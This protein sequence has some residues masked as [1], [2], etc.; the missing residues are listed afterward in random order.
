MR[1]PT[2]HLLLDDK[3]MNPRYE[4]LSLDIFAEINHI[5]W[6]EICL[7]DGDA[8]AR[9]F[10]ISESG[11]FDLGTKIKISLYYLNEAGTK[12]QVFQGIVT[13]HTVELGARGQQLRIE[14]QHAAYQ[15][16]RQRNSTVFAAK[17]DGQV[18][19]E[20]LDA[21]PGVVNAS[22]ASM[23]GFKHEGL[24][25]YFATD[26]DFML[27]RCQA[28]GW[29]V[30][31]TPL[32]GLAIEDGPKVAAS[33]PNNEVM[34]FNINEIYDIEISLDAADQYE[35]ATAQ[36]WDFKTQ[37]PTTAVVEPGTKASPGDMNPAA[38]KGVS[39]GIT[40]KLFNGTIMEP[41]ELKAWTK[42]TMVRARMAFMRGRFEVQGDAK[43]KPGE[44]CKIIDVGK[45]F[46]G[47]AYITGVRHR[48]NTAGWFTDV[49]I[50]MPDKPHFRAQA[51]ADAPSGGLIPG[52]NGIQLGIVQKFKADAVGQHRVQVLLPGMEKTTN[53]IWA[54]MC[55]PTAGM[56]KGEKGS[57]GMVFWPEEGDEVIVGFLNDDPRAAI[58]LGS[59]YN[60]MHKPIYEQ[61][62]TN[63]LM[64][65]TSRSG[66]KIEFNDGDKIKE[67]A[68]CT[69]EK[70]EVRINE[71]DQC[72]TLQDKAAKAVF[73][74]GKEGISMEFEGNS[75]KITKEGVMIEGAKSKIDLASAGI[76][77]N[78]N[79]KLDIKAKGASLDGGPTVEI[80]GG[81]VELK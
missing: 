70:M 56:G 4:V 20:L 3:D 73:K 69:L 39:A 49:Q 62:A 76:V 46:N 65:W 6:A 22:K 45:H 23:R 75:L 79:S 80:K 12:D 15:M 67:I 27:S 5:P 71:I 1:V 34:N 55:M 60:D 52:I 37:K 61:T 26:W 77:I 13:R 54:R 30:V 24:V 53:L 47:V 58:V 36:A 74:L 51:L 57:R 72:I 78:S 28:N 50:G 63:D 38:I 14:C 40:Q 33:V 25:Q 64:G 35:S 48:V 10:V 41:D 2:L 31:P 29:L 68:L 42:G 21:H 17:M 66:S 11:D 81:M 59:L 8:A 43:I 16:T 9:K 18:I 32:G 7:L 44:S 19:S